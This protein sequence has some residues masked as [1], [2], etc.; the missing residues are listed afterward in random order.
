M[1]MGQIKIEVVHLPSFSCVCWYMLILTGNYRLTCTL[2]ECILCYLQVSQEPGN[3]EALEKSQLIEPLQQHI[4]QA[5]GLY[6]RGDYQ[7]VINALGP[8]L[9]VSAPTTVELE[10]SR[11]SVSFSLSEHHSIAHEKHRE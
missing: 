5:K 9:E 3:T 7:G 10:G 8:I 11:L 1:R 6:K 4:E 2:P